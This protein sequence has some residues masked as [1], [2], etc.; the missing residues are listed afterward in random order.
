MAFAVTGTPFD[1]RTI[2]ESYILLQEVETLP[3]DPAQIAA[4]LTKTYPAVLVKN[5][6]AITTGETLLQAFD[7]M[8]VMECTAAS[9][10][11]A[12]ALG[13]IVHITPEEIERIRRTFHL[14]E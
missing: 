4:H 11:Q 8:E 5:E 12:K 6:C 1:T 7:R 3:M 2:P 9:I 13:E 14:G 10:L